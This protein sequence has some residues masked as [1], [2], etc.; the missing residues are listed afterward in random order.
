ML[1]G[2]GQPEKEVMQSGLWASG[3]A[4]SRLEALG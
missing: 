4:G 1:E 2:C 3:K